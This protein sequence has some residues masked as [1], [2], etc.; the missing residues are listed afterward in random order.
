MVR[1]LTEPCPTCK[2][3]L[4]ESCASKKSP[5]GRSFSKGDIIMGGVACPCPCRRGR[6][7]PLP[8]L[9]LPKLPT[10]RSD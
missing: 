6:T 10:P 9:N 3:E 2:A 4:H 1:V 5:S 7:R 8:K